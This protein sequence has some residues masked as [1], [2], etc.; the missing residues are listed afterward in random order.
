[1]TKLAGCALVTVLLIGGEAVAAPDLAASHNEIA[2]A[3]RQ[4][5]VGKATFDGSPIVDIQ[6]H[7]PCT[8]VFTTSM[9]EVSIDWAHVPNPGVRTVSGKTDIELQH[10]DTISH[11]VSP[12]P[13]SEIEPSITVLYGDCQPQ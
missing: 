4:D 2:G 6:Q 12:L 1:M 10:D 13:A 9:G 11:L 3:M 5:L 7:G 8:T